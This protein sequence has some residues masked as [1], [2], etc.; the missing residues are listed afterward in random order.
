[1]PQSIPP[2]LTREYVLEALADLDAGIEH[3]FGQPTKFEVVHEGN[4]Y[5][6]KA[7]IGLACR[8]SLGRLLRLAR[9]VD[10][11]RIGGQGQAF[12][13]FLEAGRKLGMSEVEIVGAWQAC[14]RVMNSGDW[15]SVERD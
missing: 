10:V 4:R 7:V 14:E 6:P 9:L 12:R 8:Y 3:P 15:V 2:G 13:D 11:F 1:M 5:P